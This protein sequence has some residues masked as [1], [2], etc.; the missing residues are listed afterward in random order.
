MEAKVSEQVVE[1]SKVWGEEMWEK[2]RMAEWESDIEAKQRKLRMSL[3]KIKN[4]K[5][6]CS[7]FIGKQYKLCH[8]P[9]LRAVSEN[10]HLTHD[11]LYL[12]MVFKDTFI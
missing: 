5:N 4:V 11:R 12:T 7:T 1:A 3:I 2:K 8:M 10:W 6:V 9:L